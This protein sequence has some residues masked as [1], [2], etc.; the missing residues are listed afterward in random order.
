MNLTNLLRHISLRHVRFQKAQ[1]VISLAGISLGVAAIVS[2]GIV[3]KSVL[4]SFEDSFINATGRAALQVTGAQSGFPESILD[5]VREVPGVE[6]AVPVID[7]DGLLPKGKERSIMILGVD[8]LTDGQIRNYSLADESADIPDPLLFLAKPDSILIT[9]A[10]AEREGIKIDQRMQVETVQGTRTFRVRG[11]LNPEGPAKVMGGNLALMDIYAAQMAFGKEGRIDRVDVSL[12]RGEKLETVQQ[13]IRAALPE[14]YTVETPAGRTRQIEG[15]LSKFQ[16]GLNLISIFAIVVG[17]YLIYNAVSISI[18][19]RRKEIGILRALGTTRGQIMRLFLAETLVISIIASMLGVG[20]GILF[21]GSIV[22]VL[23]KIV[24]IWYARTTVT[25]ISLSWLYPVVGILCGIAASLAAAVFP[26][27]AGSRISPI[28]AIRSL[29]W[30]EEGFF[31]GKRLN[32]AA[33]ISILLAATVYALYSVAEDSPLFRNSAFLFSSQIFLLLGISLITPAFLR[34]FLSIFHRFLA[35]RLGSTGMLAGLNLRKNITRNAVAV[36]AIFFGI[37]VFVNSAGFVYSFKASVTTWLDAVVRADIIVSDGHP[38]SSTNAQTIPMP[39]EMWRDIEK[40]PGV[41]SADPWRKLYMDYKGKR[42]LLSTVDIVRRG[43]Y[44]KFMIISGED[45]EIRSLLPNRD[46]V[47]VSETFAQQ[48][49]VKRGDTITIPA[50]SGAVRCRVVAVVVDYLYDSGTICMDINTFQRHWGDRLADHFSVRVRPGHDIAQVRDAIQ[51][52]LGRDRKLFV[53][54]V[55]EFKEEVRKAMDQTFIFNYAL[56]VITM[57]IA[58]FGIIITLLASVLERTREIGVI[59]SIG[60]L[61]RQVSGVV[62]LESLLMGV[63]GGILG[64]GAGMITGRLTLEG[65]N[66]SSAAQY[67]IPYGSIAWALAMAAGLSALAGIYPA[68]RAAKTNIV[69]AL[70]YE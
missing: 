69:E 60:M 34:G 22:G 18:V 3:N 10:M 45:Q 23:G 26:V 28:S 68:R 29:P 58:G 19:H 52:R 40:V 43:E 44:S 42:V 57:T 20:L 21:A 27:L 41:L 37:S 59:R 63:A 67:F 70:T 32:I 11:I 17:M 8:V 2:I 7:T 65:A 14:G 13:R 9:K 38:S 24:S 51:N 16:T 47:V 30:S 46:N 61:R 62:L 64:C 56:S 36:A 33:I 1:T 55:R 48:F 25:G 4:R 6:Y 12:L 15:M 53:L 66:Y 35:L 39:V 31:T 49:G 50:P 54:P 5:R